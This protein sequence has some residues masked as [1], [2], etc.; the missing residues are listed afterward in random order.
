MT[1]AA[2]R[3][4]IDWHG[5]RRG[6]RLPPYRQDLI[7]DLL[8]RLRVAPPSAGGTLDLASLFP[9]PPSQLWLEVGFGSGEHLAE[10]A[11]R[12]PEIGFIGCEVFV[13][14]VAALVGQVQRLR[15][16]NIRIFDDDARLLLATLPEASIDRAFLLFPDP[17]PKTR[18]AKRRF[19]GPANLATMA[20]I[21]A[22]AA[23]FHVA[24]DDA[25]Y[26]RWAL[27]QLIG[28]PDFRWKATGPGDW[29]SPPDDWVETRYQRK[30]MAARRRPV[31]LCFQRQSRPGKPRK[32]LRF[33]GRDLY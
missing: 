24:T 18:H 19:I 21:L 22:D 5:R 16:A 1:D 13:N 2:A 4:R 29:R 26:V 31:F 6:R 20:H 14:G 11:R 23:E 25:G 28:H 32:S 12:H 10:Q 15:L 33:A 8:P 3:G 30:A 17:W 27:Q 9:Q 7:A